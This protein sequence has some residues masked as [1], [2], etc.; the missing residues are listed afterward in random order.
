[1]TAAG[2]SG[3]TAAAAGLCADYSAPLTPF[4]RAAGVKHPALAPVTAYTAPLLLPVE[5]VQPGWQVQIH[6]ET[7]SVYAAAVA[8]LECEDV[9]HDDMCST[10]ITY[11]ATEVH[12]RVLSDLTVRIPCE[13]EPATAP[14]G[15]AP[16][17]IVWMS[18][19]RAGLD[20]HR[21]TGDAPAPTG[22]DRSTRTGI[23]LEA[24]T[25]VDRYQAKPCP[26]CWPVTT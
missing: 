21:R 15:P 4:E 20:M 5:Y 25:A 6:T 9:D 24:G 2:P 26:R 3:A 8:V 18:V 11:P 13:P 7:G 12:Y 19:G 17:D 1:M 16:G 14:A 22:C 23:V 10:V